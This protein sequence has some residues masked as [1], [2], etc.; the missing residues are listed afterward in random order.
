MTCAGCGKHI[1]RGFN[2]CMECSNKYGWHASDRPEWLNFLISEN[3]KD[4]DAQKEITEFS[5]DYCEDVMS[6]YPDQHLTGVFR[7]IYQNGRPCEDEALDNISKKT[8]VK[9]LIKFFGGT[10]TE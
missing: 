3:Q 10:I 4:K 1:T 7:E 9:R 5:L 2:I 8:V 6:A